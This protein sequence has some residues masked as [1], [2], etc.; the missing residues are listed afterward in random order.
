MPA[1]AIL[2]QTTYAEL[3]ERCAAAA[4]SDAFPEKGSFTSKKI[5]GR[6][7]WYF[8]LPAE[9]GRAQR[10]VGPETPEL[11]ERISHHRENR[12]DE[13]E[14]TA[15]VSSL[16][17]H[18]MPRPLPEI[19][20][21]AAALAKAGV[22]RRSVMVGT[23]A[24]QTYPAVLGEK[25]PGQLLQTGDTD[26]AQFASTS[27]AVGDQTIPVLDILRSV[28]GTFR[29]VPNVARGKTTSYQ[30]RGA[31][32]V[33]FLTPMEGPDFDEPQLLP[34]LQTY[35]QPLRFLDFLIHEPQPA[36][37]L[38]GPG[39]YVSVPQPQRFAVHK[40][41]VAQRRIRGTAKRDKDIRQADALLSVLVR[42]RN[43]E[44][45]QAWEEAEERGAGWQQLLLEGLSLLPQSSR[46]LTL[47][48]I[49]RTRSAVPRLDLTFQNPPPRYVFDR[50]V[51]VFDGEA[52]GEAVRCEVSRETLEDH[53]D[54]NG[55]S[56]DGWIVT[57]HENRTAIEAM[58]RFKYLSWPVEQAGTVL[59]KT[60]D[61]PR[62]LKE[63]SQRPRRGAK[64]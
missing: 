36:V 64:I 58:A 49:G 33:D 31:F 61:A 59:I 10:Y 57:F 52:N 44:L 55:R 34:A 41:I 3:L 60:S 22:F 17:R 37:M 53:V 30:A 21:I 45:R 28:D 13:R 35:A 62:L 2:I 48:A 43:S 19:G 38:Q 40:L 15:L 63:I 47:K 7:Y 8:Q 23:A 5:K 42:H 32:R 9:S 16:V 24:F 6:L 56:R 51:I 18:G 46:D 29:A 1:P 11:L 26:I 12:N 50:D 27:H 25:L 4:F 54:A 20:S 14:R 39:I